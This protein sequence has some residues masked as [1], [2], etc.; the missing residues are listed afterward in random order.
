MLLWVVAGMPRFM[1]RDQ[2]SQRV[3]GIRREQSWGRELHFKPRAKSQRSE[4][5]IDKACDCCGSGCLA[6]IGSQRRPAMVTPA[7]ENRGPEY[8]REMMDAVTHDCV[9]DVGGLAVRC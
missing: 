8:G 9:T 2:Q 7:L 5:E 4:T 6:C 1:G 3:H